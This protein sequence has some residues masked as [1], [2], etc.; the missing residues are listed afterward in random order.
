M[1]RRSLSRREFLATGAAGT[2]LLTRGFGQATA[3]EDVAELPAPWHPIRIRG[4]IATARSGIQGVAISD[5][6]S[7]TSSGPDGAFELVSHSGRRHVFFSVPSGYALPR[8]TSGTARFYAPLNDGKSGEASMFFQLQEITEPEDDHLFF[9]LADPQTEDAGEMQRFLDETV[10][11]VSATRA[12]WPDLQA[13][14]IGCG[15]LMWD[16]LELFPQYEEAVR[17]MEIPFFQ[18]VG[19]HDLDLKATT[20][21]ESSRTFQDHFGPDY[22]SFNRGAVHYVVLNDVFWHGRSYIG[23]VGEEQLKWLEADLNLV[24]PGRTVVVALHIPLQ[25][26][27][28]AR[29]GDPTAL[30]TNVQNRERLYRMLEPYNVHVL[31]GHTHECEH[32]QQGNVMEHVHGAVCG[33][34]WTGPVCYDGAPCGY[35]IYE[36]RGEE[37]RWQYKATGRPLS[38]QLS[39]YARGA[40][41]GAPQEVVANVWNWDP[42]W[43]VVWY[44]DGERR[45]E[46]SRRRGQDPEARQL[47]LGPELPEK[48]PWVDPVAVDHL[49]YAPVSPQTR[50]ITIEATDRFGH[51]FSRT[52]E[53]DEPE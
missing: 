46:M 11:D 12:L 8:N 50:R 25:S 21:E 36:V 38:E 16:N 32:I 26:T 33:A 6:V 3:Q 29:G 49:F 13:F 37:V 14:G 31:S 47:Y 45:G 7:V 24:E 5:G 19:N 10:P 4:R 51:T 22:Y 43:E 44:E 23:Y 30:R 48:R 9:L 53:K 27:A 15:D 20:H 41:S 39:V 52:V 18:V 28:G 17:R 1:K 42:A 35:G 34:W 40:D 2:A